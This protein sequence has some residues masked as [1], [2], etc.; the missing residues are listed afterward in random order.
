[1]E[2]KH[3][4]LIGFM[5]AGKTTIGRRLSYLAKKPFLDMDQY[6]EKQEGR[7]IKEIFAT[8]GECVFRAIETKSL[9]KIKLER[10]KY[11]ISTGGGMPIQEKNQKLLKEMGTIIYLRIQAETVCE[12]IKQDSK[13]PLLQVE[14]PRQKIAEMLKV[15]NPIYEELADYIIDVDQKQFKD[16]LQEIKVILDKDGGEN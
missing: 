7:E 6:I 3:I 15:R 12:R 1:M 9:E 2:N 16:I 11:V 13:R 4:I 8:E 10:A 14:N 5:G